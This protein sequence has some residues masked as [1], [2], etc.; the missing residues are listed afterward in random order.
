MTLSGGTVGGAIFSR[1][2]ANV[3]IYGGTFTHIHAED[4][5]VTT[6]YGKDFKLDGVNVEYG[7]LNDIIEDLENDNIR[8][9]TGVLQNGQSL[10]CDLKFGLY[11]FPFLV[12]FH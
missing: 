1:D 10:N 11:T 7:L 8:N 4:Q 9:L 5:S 2:N 12:S 3:D 6:I